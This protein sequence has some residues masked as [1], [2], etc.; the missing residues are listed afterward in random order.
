MKNDLS[1][2]TTTL[3]FNHKNRKNRSCTLQ[4]CYAQNNS[5]DT[6]KDST[7]NFFYKSNVCIF[8]NV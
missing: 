5:V 2:D 6:F 3:L 4:L 8:F 7:V 1:D